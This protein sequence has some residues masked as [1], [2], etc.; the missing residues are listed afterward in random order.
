MASIN[1]KK[2][3]AGKWNKRCLTLDEK[4]KILDGVKKR[5]LSCRVIAE[6]FKIGKTQAANVVKNEAKLREEYANF[7]G[8]GLKH[9]KRENHQKF[10]P[11]NDILYSWFKKCESSGIYINAPLLKEEAMSIKQSLNLPELDSFKASE[12]WLDKWKLSHGIKEKQISGESLDV[13]QTTVESWMEQI[14]ELH[15][16]YDQRHI[17]NMDESGCFFKALPAKGLAQKGKKTKGGK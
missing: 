9:I 16:G 7:Q 13:S 17:L 8:K 11:I 3:E 4:I 10:K 5:K 6:E 14:K 2:R 12:G 1:S 15:K